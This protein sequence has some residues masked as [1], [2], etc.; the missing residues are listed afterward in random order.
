MPI[1]PGSCAPCPASMTTRRTPSPSCRASDGLPEERATPGTGRA[2][3][4]GAGAVFAAAVAA[5][6]LRPGPRRRRW[7]GVRAPAARRRGRGRNRGVR[8]LCAGERRKRD[9][10][11]HRLGQVARWKCGGRQPGARRRVGRRRTGSGPRRPGGGRR[12]NRSAS[13]HVDDDPEGILHREDAVGAQPV[14]LEH[15]PHAV[16][17]E[18]PGPDAE[19]D[20]VVHQDRLAEPFL[21][22]RGEQ[23]DVQPRRLAARPSDPREGWSRSWSSDRDR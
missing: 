1:A 4:V 3:R 19:E 10:F 20:A 22:E 14:D 16:G 18:L 23:I 21:D 15:H 7:R 11:G 9:E 2:P 6:A 12:D 17:R 8:G 13:G 5:A